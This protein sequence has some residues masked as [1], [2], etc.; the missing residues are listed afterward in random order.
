MR[1]LPTRGRGPLHATPRPVGRHPASA[2]LRCALQLAAGCSFKSASGTATSRPG[3]A[4]LSTALSGLD[5]LPR[6]AG[7]LAREDDAW[8]L[9]CGRDALRVAAVAALAG[10]LSAPHLAGKSRRRGVRPGCSDAVPPC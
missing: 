5:L 3:A 6:A 8:L 7:P 2:L 1:G 10:L 4:A 9:W